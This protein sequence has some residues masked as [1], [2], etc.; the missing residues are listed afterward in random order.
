V[1]GVSISKTVFFIIVLVCVVIF[2]VFFTFLL[3]FVLFVFFLLLRLDIL[4]H[5]DLVSEDK[6]DTKQ[7]ETY[8]ER[9]T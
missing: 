2:L 1:G 7:A 3:N 4:G 9:E 6:A 5:V 8:L